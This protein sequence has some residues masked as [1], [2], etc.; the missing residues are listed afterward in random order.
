M[1]RRLFSGA[2][3]K[4]RNG[5]IRSGVSWP[6][7]DSNADL[8]FRKPSFYPLNY[9]AENIAVRLRQGSAPQR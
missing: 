1:W 8:G 3:E 6:H 2:E 9:R 7:R 5:A 4:R